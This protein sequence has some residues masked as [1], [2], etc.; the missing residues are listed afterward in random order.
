MHR[1]EGVVDVQVGQGGQRVGE[2]A[3]LGVVLAG[4]A[5]L[6]A[7]VL[8]QHDPVGLGGPDDLGGRRADDVLGQPDGRAEQL[9][10]AV[11]D[12]RQAVPGVRLALRPAQVRHDDRD[13]A[14]VEQVPQQRDAGPDAAVVGDAG[15]VERDVQVA[16]DQ[17]PLA[18]DVEVGSEPHRSLPTSAM[19]STRRLE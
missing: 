15:A 7:D 2:G 10:E 8:Q 11:A 4:L 19:R 12:G 9:A 17:D 16:A 3:A 13:R 18:G 14:A 5:R 1:A 6:E